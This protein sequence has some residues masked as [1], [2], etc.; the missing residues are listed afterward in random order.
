M[1]L[2][3]ESSGS[4]ILLVSRPST[5]TSPEVGESSR[6]IILSRVDLPF[7]DLPRM[8]TKSLAP[9]SRFTPLRTT[10]EPEYSF[11][12]S[13]S[14]RSAIRSPEDDVPVVVIDGRALR[15]HRSPVA[16]ELLAVEGADVSVP[17]HQVVSHK[18]CRSGSSVGT[19]EI[20]IPARGVDIDT[21]VVG[22]E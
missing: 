12:I 10:L 6:P 7:P 9:T 13:R 19:L 16:G 2:I 5:R 3:L 21:E 17:C 15:Q 20:V 4:F 1:S 8:T 11:R 14:E 18:V 22:Q